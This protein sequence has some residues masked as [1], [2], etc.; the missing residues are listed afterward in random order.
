M[1]VDLIFDV[2]LVRILSEDPLLPPVPLLPPIPLLPTIVLCT[3]FGTNILDINLVTTDVDLTTIVFNE[4]VPIPL[5]P[6]DPLV[7]DIK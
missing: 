6:L 1:S 7:D 3:T 2:Q 4:E 5:L